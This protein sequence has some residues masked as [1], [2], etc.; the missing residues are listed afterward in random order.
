MWVFHSSFIWFT[1]AAEKS[2]IHYEATY[3]LNAV[4]ANGH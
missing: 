3:T 2:T 1:L 4:I